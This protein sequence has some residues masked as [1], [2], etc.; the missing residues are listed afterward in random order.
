MLSCFVLEAVITITNADGNRVTSTSDSESDDGMIF[1]K[2]ALERLSSIL[3]KAF[4]GHNI[5]DVRKAKVGKHMTYDKFRDWRNQKYAIVISSLKTSL[6][7]ISSCIEDALSSTNKQECIT[8]EMRGLRNLYCEGKVLDLNR[9]QN[10]KSDVSDCN[11]ALDLE[12]LKK[13]QMHYKRVFN[14][15]HVYCEIF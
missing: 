15:E 6:F 8:A 13:Q 3:P 2:V 5:R 10:V 11:K 1:E 14:E 4:I 7:E 9:I 12:T